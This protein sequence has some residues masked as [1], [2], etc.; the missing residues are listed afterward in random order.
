MSGNTLGLN[1]TTYDYLVQHGVRESA[2]LQQCRLE[3]AADPMARMQ[4]APE[5][6]Q[7]IALLCQLLQ[8][9]QAV[10]IGTFTGYSSLSMA[11]VLP[12]DGKLICLD[13]DPIS[14]RAAQGYWQRAKVAHKIDLRLAPALESL[15]ILQNEWAGQVDLVFIDADK[16][17]YLAYYEQALTLLRPNG[18]ILVDNVLWSGRV[19]DPVNQEAD[20]QALHQFNLFVQQDVRVD[21]AMLPLPDGLTLLRKREVV[22]Q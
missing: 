8:V 17:N 6:G 11:Q 9:K 3:T 18:V 20:T 16:T 22:N 13:I 2:I 12:N 19:A 14:T 15:E 10:E 7:F 1:Q 5:Q 4:I 21:L